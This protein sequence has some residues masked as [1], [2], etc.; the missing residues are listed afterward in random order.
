MFERRATESDRFWMGH[1][2]QRARFAAEQGEVPIGAL[3]VCKGAIVGAG[4]NGTE[5]DQDATAHA[6]M[7]ALRQAAKAMGSRRLED[8]VLYVTLEPCAMC[9]GAIVLARVPRLVFGAYDPKAGACG[10]LRNVV[11]DPRLNHTC[12][13]IGGVMHKECAGLL[14]SFFG[15]LRGR[16]Q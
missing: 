3:L 12:Q 16:R 4:W 6:E 2:L 5:R 8:S 10:T 7:V 11:Q 15:G 9:A 1:A 14:Q 13:A